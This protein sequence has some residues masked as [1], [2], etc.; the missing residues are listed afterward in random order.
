MIQPERRPTLEGTITIVSQG[1]RVCEADHITQIVRLSFSSTP[2]AVNHRRTRDQTTDHGLVCYS[3]CKRG[4]CVVSS[5]CWQSLSLPGLMPRRLGLCSG[6]ANVTIETW[7]TVTLGRSVCLDVYVCFFEST[8]K[9]F[10]LFWIALSSIHDSAGLAL[11][12]MD[13]PTPQVKRLVAR[14]AHITGLCIH[15]LP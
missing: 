8:T 2:R 4:R 10:L 6:V 12:S 1:S 14:L 11:P 5:R 3:I 9:L 15:L 7:I 13:W